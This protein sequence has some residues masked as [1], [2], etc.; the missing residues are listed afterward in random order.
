MYGVRVGSIIAVALL[1]ACVLPIASSQVA[2]DAPDG[3]PA[4]VGT[5]E[6]IVLRVAM[7]DDVKSLNPLVAG[8]VWTWNVLG[9]LYDTPLSVDLI[10]SE[11]FIPYIAIHSLNYS[12]SSLFNLDNKSDWEPSAKAGQITVYYNFTNV[13]FHDG[14]QMDINDIMFSFG[15][16]AIQPDWAA[17]VKCLMDKGGE[18][19]SNYSDTHWLGMKKYY[20]SADGKIAALRFYLQTP[21]ADFIRNTLSVFILP[22]HIWANIIGG[23]DYDNAD[24]FLPAT[25]PRCWSTA[26]ALAFENKEAIGSGPF[27][28]DSWTPGQQARINTWREHFSRQQPYID[29][30]VFKIYKTAEQAVQALQQGDVDYIAWSI[31]P[32]YV[33]DLINDENIGIS[34]SAEKGFKY[35]AFN[36]RKK[37]FGYLD[38]DPAKGDYG[39]PLRQAIAYCI[40]KKEIVERILQNFG[41]AADGPISAID[42]EWF[43]ESIPQYE[44]NITKAKETLDYG[45]DGIDGTSD[46]YQLTDPTK[47]PGRGNW[48]KNPDGTPIGS[49]DGGK[50]EILTPPA[51]YDP[52]AAQPGIMMATQMQNVGINAESIAL[53]FGT[54]VT[55]VDQRN[56]DMFEMGWR[57]GSDPTDFMYAFFHSDNTE[58]GQNY[59]GYRNVSFDALL[60]LARSTNDTA[61]KHKAIRDAQAA[62]AYDQPYNVLYFKTNIEAYRSDRFVNWTV[63]PTGSIFSWRSIMGIHP[64]GEYRLKATMSVESPVPSASESDIIVTVKDQNGTLVEGATV[65]LSCANGTFA[66]GLREC[67]ATTLGNGQAKIEWTAPYVPRNAGNDTKVAISLLGAT[68]GRI[69]IDYDPAPSKASVIIVK[70]EGATFLRLRIE[71]ETDVLEPGTTT[72]ITVTVKDQVGNPVEGATV[73]AVPSEAGLTIS[74]DTDTNSDGIAVLEFR[75]NSSY[76]QMHTFAVDIIVSHPDFGSASGTINF[77][78]PPPP[79]PPEPKEPFISTQFVVAIGVICV[80]VAVST[81]FL[82]MRRYVRSPP[83][84]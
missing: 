77:G 15:I 78:I 76:L 6:E 36:M 68:K 7:Q 28:F 53:D 1:L 14:H 67:N 21:F 35:L 59:P 40:N 54:I 64:P 23:Q 65:E 72:K 27:K 11:K 12:T 48:W 81:F 29:A 63:G 69:G 70:K 16:Q 8:D 25:D 10:D 30:I 22:Q 37:S 73:E 38:N 47:P 74:G 3:L 83:R 58:S 4:T 31:P 55:R 82:G 46:D 17:S 44:F 13:K 57:I 43:N 18:A 20:E 45:A 39:K 24:P 26:K 60:D 50:I 9:Y 5:R 52:I 80:A 32:T 34:Q 75:A 56:F 51:D 62:I 33:P 19:G 49:G 66:N 2:D 71:V 61:V 84:K 79:P 41:I 42:T